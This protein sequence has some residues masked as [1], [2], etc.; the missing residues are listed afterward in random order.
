MGAFYLNRLHALSALLSFLP[1]L[2]F[3]GQA[4]TNLRSSYA[5]FEGLDVHENL[6]PA[7]QRL[8]ETKAA[9]VIPRFEST[10]DPHEIL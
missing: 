10:V 8:D 3:E 7:L 5:G 1:Y 6:L 9:L 4:L 2:N